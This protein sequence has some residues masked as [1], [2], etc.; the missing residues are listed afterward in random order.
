MLLL[1]LLLPLSF[2]AGDL[3]Y[4]RAE[5]FAAKPGG[6]SRRLDRTWIFAERQLY[7]PYQ[8]LLHRYTDRQLFMDTRLRDN[9]SGEKSAFYRDIEILRNAGLDG[10]GSLDYYNVHR[11][12]LKAFEKRPPPAGYSQMFVVPAYFPNEHL[13]KMKEMIL[14]VAKSAY[15]TRLDGK[16]VFWAYGGGTEGQQ[17]WAKLLRSDPEIPPFLF[18]GDMPF[19]DMYEAYGKYERNRKN[20]RPIPVEEV[21]A[22]RAKVAS[23][24]QVLDGF[25]IWCTELVWD[26]SGEYPTRSMAT[27]IYRKYLRPVVLEVMA[28]PENKGKLLGTYLRQGYVNPFTGVTDGE[29]GTRTLRNYLDEILLVNPDL[30]MCFEWNEANENTHFQPTVAHG[31]TWERILAYYRSLLDRVPPTP[32]PGDDPAIP[33]LV[34]SVRQA[35]KLGEPWH[36]ELLYL[37]DGATAKTVNVSARLFSNDGKL[38]T[39]FSDETFKTDE[40]KAVDL[41][42]ASE[43]LADYDAVV[44]EIETEFDGRKEQWAGFDFTRIRATTCKDYLYSHHPLRELLRPGKVDFCAETEQDGV[45]LTATFECGEPLA[46]LEVLDDLDEVAAVDHENVFDRSKYA[47]VRGIF[48]S[49]IPSNFGK[50]AEGVLRG[51]TEIIGAPGAKLL[52][53][54]YAWEGF[55]VNEL[56]DECKWKTSCYFGGGRSTFFALIPKEELDDAKIVFDFNKLEKIT[57]TPAQAVEFGR[58]AYTFEKTARLELERMDDLADYPKPVGENNAALDLVLPPLGR[59]PVYQLRAVTESGKVWRSKPVIPSKRSGKKV[60]IAVFSESERKPVECSVAADRI[61]GFKYDFNPRLGAFMAC[62]EGRR[63]DVQLGGADVYARGMDGAAERGALPEGFVRPEPEWVEHDGKW[64]IKFDGKGSYLR[65]PQEV[66]PRGAPYTL[67]FEIKPD[68]VENQVLLRM[69]GVTG[70]DEALQLVIIDGAL[71]VTHF[72]IQ[73]WG[74]KPWKTGLKPL[75]GEWNR[76][77]VTKDFKSIAC[78]VNGK[79]WSVPYERR[80]RHFNDAIFGSNVKAGSGVPEGTKPFKGLLRSLHVTHDTI[81]S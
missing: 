67:E 57:V 80:A 22:F 41:R 3:P 31:R 51:T 10:F 23:A 37:P 52:S 26:Y 81:D 42:I 2:Y 9:P 17:R 27:D 70:A 60:T 18:V 24:A 15:S 78:T 49:L 76:I 29:F 64:M 47:I 7:G 45:R 30:L 79:K 55:G 43:K 63:W 35:I 12:Q 32:R 59:F 16:L 4:S 44:L 46:S 56:I 13:P 66:I 39:H 72:G 40:L 14:E 34:V 73:M 54:K 21:E 71:E 61:P 50:G 5:S 36:C 53:G 75:P 1:L 38:L 77:S 68:S 58:K 28:R 74:V 25:Q 65:L 33:N 69:R 8:N 20:P 6:R 62:C 19:Y 11:S 48:T